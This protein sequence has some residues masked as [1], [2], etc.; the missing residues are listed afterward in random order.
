MAWPYYLR[1][2]FFIYFSGICTNDS[3]YVRAI[4]ALA[5]EPDLFASKDS[6]YLDFLN[7]FCANSNAYWLANFISRK[8]HM[9]ERYHIRDKQEKHSIQC[10][11]SIKRYEG[12]LK[13]CS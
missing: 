13:S 12:L 4:W 8:D 5:Q 1:A 3:L 11:E 9:G 10:G 6:L 7:K 2:K